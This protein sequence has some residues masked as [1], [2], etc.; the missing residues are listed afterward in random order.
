VTAIAVRALF[1]GTNGRTPS[2]LACLALAG[3]GVGLWSVLENPVAALALFLAA[4]VAG[5]APTLRDTWR[6]PRNEAAAPWLL[7]LAGSS[8]N[9]ALVDIGSWAAGAGGFA[10]WGFPVYLAAVNGCI[11]VLIARRKL[12][13]GFGTCPACGMGSI[14]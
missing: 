9:L 13:D 3:G 10:V 4:D 6:D 8:L 5:A 2:D 7:G 11:L 12:P 1:R 14:G